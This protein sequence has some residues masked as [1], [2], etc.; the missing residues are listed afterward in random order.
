M[1][2]L[3]A[4]T[5]GLA[6]AGCG[7][8]DDSGTSDATI[9]MWTFKRTHVAALEQAAATFKEKTGIT[10]KVEAFTPDDVF[11][12]KIQSA[13]Q[14]RDLPDVLELH[15][16]GED[17]R[18]G[19]GGLLTDLKGDFDEAKLQRFLPSTREAGRVTDERKAKIE[20]LANATVGTLYSVPFTAGTFGIVYANK[21]KMAAAGL[22]PDT[23]PKTWEEFLTYL[24]ATTKVDAKQGGLSLGLKVTQT[25]F[26]WVYEQL[27]FAY[28]GADRFKALF[29]QQAGQGFASADGIKTLELYSQLKPYWIPGA[30]ALGIDEA[31]VAFA[32]G[33]SAFNVGGTF[34][35]AFLSQND[36]KPEKLLTFPVPPATG[37][38]VSDL[39]LA[40]LALTGLAVT[41]TSKQRE[42]SVKWLDFLT[43]AEGAGIF[44]K[45]SLDLPATDLGSQAETLIGKDLAALQKFFTGP[46]E[47][48]YDAADKSFRPPDYDEV[49]VGNPLLKMS[50]LGEVAPAATGAE[51][52]KVLAAMWQSK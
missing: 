48:M 35:M 34:T 12:S 1:A 4:A 42:A 15:A 45:A 37:G 13:A 2:A 39:R 9:S 21:D 46:P 19:G 47:S 44:A 6:A 36:M 26:N 52:D 33:K 22:D 17:M 10:V 23:P 5:L 41:E 27:A 20:E 30:S 18:V 3:A 24:Q 28:L 38:K 31:D 43:G 29:G 11:T 8:D 16:G 50:P 7:G 49:E 14:T 25:G 51:L 40:P 32:Q